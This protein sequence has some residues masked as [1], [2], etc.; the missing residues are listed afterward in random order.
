DRGVPFDKILVP[1]RE[2]TER[3]IGLARRCE[4]NNADSN[5]VGSVDP[6]LAARPDIMTYEVQEGDTLGQLATQFGMNIW[7]ILN[8]NSLSDP[9]LIRPG[10]RLKVLPVNGVEHEIQPGE[11]LAD[12]AEFYQVD[13]G[14]L[15]DFN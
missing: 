9:D 4:G 15:V 6:A 8:A 11:K 5:A 1:S 2:T 3:A 7:T 14:P 13:L 12:I 10:M